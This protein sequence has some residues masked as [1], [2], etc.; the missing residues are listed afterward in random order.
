MPSSDPDVQFCPHC[1]ESITSAQRH[2]REDL[3]LDRY[4]TE[5]ECPACGYHGEVFRHGEGDSDPDVMTDGGLSEDNGGRTN[6]RGETPT[7]AFSTAV[8][9]AFAPLLRDAIR[10]QD[11]SGRDARE[12]LHRQL[13]GRGF[14]I[15]QDGEE[16]GSS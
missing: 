11:I 2:F 7:E 15:E 5:F 3:I 6:I 1:G 10:G 12:R 14:T 4:R 13:E 16:G 9:Q 8:V